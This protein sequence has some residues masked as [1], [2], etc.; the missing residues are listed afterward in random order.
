MQWNKF[1]NTTDSNEEWLSIGDPIL[2]RKGLHVERLR[3]WTE[4]YDKHFIEHSLASGFTPSVYT[5]LV[6]QIV[7]LLSFFRNASHF[8]H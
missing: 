5:V 7:F 8:I 6:L 4:V 2:L 3:L 1:E